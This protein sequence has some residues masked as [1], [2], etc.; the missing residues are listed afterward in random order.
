M[1]KESQ[2]FETNKKS[3]D[4]KVDIHLNSDFYNNDNFIAGENSLKEI[5]LAILGEVKG[6]KILPVCTRNIAK[7]LV[8]PL[9]RS[10]R[11]IEE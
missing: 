5:E 1:N 7:F 2:F 4:A 6:L 9:P 3:W 10:F 11:S 8:G